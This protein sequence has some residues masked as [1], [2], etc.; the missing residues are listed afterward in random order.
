MMVYRLC[1]EEYAGELLA[2]GLANRWHKERQFVIYTSGSISLCALELLA[3]TNGIRPAGNFKIMHIEIDQ[4]I[5][6]FNPDIATLPADWQQLSAYPLLQNI[7]SDWYERG[8]ELIMKIPS[9]I[10]TPEFN[11]AIHARHLD[12]H[13][14][15]SLKKTEDF[16]WDHRFPQG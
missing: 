11:Y 12:F 7:G 2:S 5:G 10:I 14:H 8:K 15:V 16:F 9:A 6:V 4:T 1:R 3:H 13:K